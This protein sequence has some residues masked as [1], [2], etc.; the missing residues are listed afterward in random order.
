MRD[1][2]GKGPVGSTCPSFWKQDISLAPSQA[3]YLFSISSSSPTVPVLSLPCLDMHL[4][5]L[6]NPSSTWLDPNLST[7]YVCF[8]SYFLYLT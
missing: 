2:V 3:C 4:L 7:L 8:F 6:Y 5:I 1:M